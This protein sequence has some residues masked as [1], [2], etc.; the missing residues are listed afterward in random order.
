MNDRRLD[1]G[2]LEVFADAVRAALG[3]AEHERLTA[4][5]LRQHV[6]EHVALA[7]DGD[8]VQLVRHGRRDGLPVRDVDARR[9]AS[10]L[11]QLETA[12]DSVAESRV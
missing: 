10:E 11:G 4:R 7:I 3:L 12:S 2:A 9:V 8:V 6:R 5:L 1:A